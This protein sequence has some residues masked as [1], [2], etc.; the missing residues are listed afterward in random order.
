MIKKIVLLAAVLFTAFYNLFSPNQYERVADKTYQIIAT[1]TIEENYDGLIAG[2]TAGGG[3]LTLYLLVRI[4]SKLAAFLTPKI[5]NLHR[6]LKE[7]IK[8]FRAFLSSVRHKIKLLKIKISI[9]IRIKKAALKTLWQKWKK[10][11][12]AFALLL[13]KWAKKVAAFFK[14]CI[15]TVLTFCFF[16]HQMILLLIKVLK[17][18]FNT[19][20]KLFKKY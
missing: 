10:R 3:T 5:K 2:T 13:K 20:K 16:I 12:I 11:F 15:L 4:F 17:K 8:R 7:K 6:I 1:G 14:I 9:E 18:C 19:I